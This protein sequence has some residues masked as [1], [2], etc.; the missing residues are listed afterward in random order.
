MND[1][2]ILAVGRL[3]IFRC[4]LFFLDLIG[5]CNTVDLVITLLFIIGAKASYI[6]PYQ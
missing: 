3:L 6:F 2:M 4:P 1:L 5:A